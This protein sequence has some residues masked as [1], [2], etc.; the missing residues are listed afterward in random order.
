[1]AL[2]PPLHGAAM[3]HRR[4]NNHSTCSSAGWH[5]RRGLG[6]QQ[7]HKESMR[8][9][10]RQGARSEVEAEALLSG[11]GGGPE[12]QPWARSTEGKERARR[13]V[14]RRPDRE[15]RTARRRG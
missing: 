11:A 7:V 2:L 5:G 12:E 15:R 8:G 9:V 4:S 6:Q 1:M 14:C 13:V 10:Y 3:V